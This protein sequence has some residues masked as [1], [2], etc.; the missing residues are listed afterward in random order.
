MFGEL[1]EDR[2]ADRAAIGVVWE[3]LGEQG[4]SH[5]SCSSWGLQ[6]RRWPWRK[7]RQR[8]TL[9]WENLKNHEVDAPEANK[10]LK[11]NL[12]NFFFFRLA[13]LSWASCDLFMFCIHTVTLYCIH[14]FSSWF[15]HEV[16]SFLC[17]CPDWWQKGS[18]LWMKISFHERGVSPLCLHSQ[19]PR[20]FPDIQ[21]SKPR[22]WGR[23]CVERVPE[24]A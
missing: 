24:V 7:R 14:S 11:N 5:S 10:Y 23:A 6:E 3:L 12:G 17:Q 16:T 22:Q 21:A 4:R 18:N 1:Q 13:K 2:K 20:C 8:S 15:T 9:H 19:L